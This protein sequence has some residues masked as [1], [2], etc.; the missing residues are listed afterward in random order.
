MNEHLLSIILFA[1]LAGMLVLLLIPKSQTNLI[2]LW[3]NFVAI[4]SFLHLQIAFVMGLFLFG[5]AMCVS[6]VAFTPERSARRSPETGRGYAIGFRS[7]TLARL[8][9]HR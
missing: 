9:R 5:L 3:A 8:R 7:G 2:R 4:G 1:P 6:Y